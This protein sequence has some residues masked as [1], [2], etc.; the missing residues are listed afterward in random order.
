M[1]C[2]PPR[3][4]A[5]ICLACL[6]VLV[7]LAA[8][9]R[10]T[11]KQGEAP[12]VVSGRAPAGPE[13]VASRGTFIVAAGTQDTWNAVGQVLVRLDGVTYEGRALM[14]GLYVVRY[15]GERFLI[16]TRGLVVTPERHGLATEVSARPV[17]G[18]THASLAAVELLGLLQQRLPMELAL[19]AAGG[20]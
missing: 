1:H 14:M 19:I 15:R 9:C 13:E 5:S 12:P 8:G 11:S 18:K 4:P 3:R 7:S 20:K 6:A 16:L 2:I 10:S 17:D